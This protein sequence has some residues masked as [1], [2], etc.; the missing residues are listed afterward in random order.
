MNVL[1]LKNASAEGPGTIEDHLRTSNVPFTIVDL[2]QGEPLAAV[3][4][5]SHLVVLGGPMAV[6]ERDRIP[7]LESE[8]RFLERA[9]NEQKHILGVCLGS[10]LLAHVLGAR[11]YPGGTREIGWYDV[12]LSDEGMRDPCMRELAVNGRKVAQVFQWHGDTFDL[13]QDAVRLASSAVY[14][15]QAFRHGDRVYALQFHIEASPAVVSRWLKH[16]QG[17]DLPLIDARSHDLY[18]AYRERARGFYR[19]FFG[20]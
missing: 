14:P 1:I 10:Q 18:P 15:N 17:I 6:Y 5:F 4:A 7:Y 8:I 2:E 11:V 16:E 9:V 3:E 20:T 19:A 12:S 13:P